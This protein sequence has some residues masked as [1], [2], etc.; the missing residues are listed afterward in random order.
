MQT[1]VEIKEGVAITGAGLRNFFKLHKD[2][3]YLL[4]TNSLKKRTLPQN[5]YMHSIFTMLVEPLRDAGWDNIRTMEDA[6]EFTK[7]LFLSVTITN[8]KTGEAVKRVRHT[9]ELSVEETI[10]FIDD[11]KK[12]ASEY[13]SFYIPDANEQ[14]KIFH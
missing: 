2:G 10:V 13:L 6:K 11:I 7:S 1:T 4:T 3:L 12:W 5:S 9:S 8:G 14:V